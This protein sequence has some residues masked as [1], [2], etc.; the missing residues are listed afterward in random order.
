[1]TKIVIPTPKMITARLA[2][3][4]KNT[5]GT[6]YYPRGHIDWTRKYHICRDYGRRK[7]TLCGRYFRQ[8]SGKGRYKPIAVYYR[9]YVAVQKRPLAKVP[10]KHLCKICIAKLLKIRKDIIDEKD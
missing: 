9:K 7:V 2:L 1:M 3:P 5:P 6:A 4:R 10:S 8:C